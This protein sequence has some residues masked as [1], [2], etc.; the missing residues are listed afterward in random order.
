[1]LGYRSDYNET[2]L[3]MSR[4]ITILNSALA[5]DK[6][7]AC[8]VNAK[9]MEKLYIWAL[10]WSI[11]SCLPKNNLERLDKLFDSIKI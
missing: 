11:G 1:M 9:M 5:F 10:Y 2:N 3:I 7:R 8:I 6:D 4:F